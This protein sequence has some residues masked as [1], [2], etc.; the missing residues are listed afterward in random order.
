M[1]ETMFS[2]VKITKTILLVGLPQL[3]LQMIHD[4]Y[5]NRVFTLFNSWKV[6]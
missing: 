6:K 2:V 4:Q 5:P 1:M 3:F